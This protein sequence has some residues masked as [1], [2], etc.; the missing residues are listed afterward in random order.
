MEWL[1]QWI[2]WL[3]VDGNWIP[4]AT[5]GV[6]GLILGWLFTRMPARSRAQE[7]EARISDLDSQVRRAS[8]RAD[9]AENEVSDLKRQLENVKSDLEKANARISSLEEEVDAKDAELTDLNNALEETRS[10]LAERE[11]KIEE[12]EPKLKTREFDLTNLQ[13]DMGA[14]RDE[15]EQALS[16]LRAE[17]DALSEQYQTAL[18]DIEALQAD[19]AEATARGEELAAEKEQ[20]LQEMEGVKE[21]AGV[22]AQ[23]AANKT[24]ALDEAFLRSTRL[25]RQLEER[26]TEYANAMAELRELRREVDEVSML[27]DDMEQKLN[28]ARGDVASELAVLT[29]TMIRMKDDALKQANRRIAVLTA[30]LEATRVSLPDHAGNAENADDA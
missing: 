7:A 15:H 17:L 23:E 4:V 21:E 20:L 22:N 2:A 27:K 6:L 1:S 13:S 9:D 5:A 19:L 25:Q 14:L 16:A 18:A 12:L 8:R 30:E 28:H 11:D 10:A 24:A 3:S 29:S 26:E